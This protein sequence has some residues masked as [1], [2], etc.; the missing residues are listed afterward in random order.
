LGHEPSSR[1]HGR[2]AAPDEEETESVVANMQAMC[3][4]EMNDAAVCALLRCFTPLSVPAGSVLWEQG[5]E[6]D[7]AVVLLSGVLRSE[8]EEVISILFSQFA[9]T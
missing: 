5:G 4:V 2:S 8:L 9:F 1:E 6:P 7:R 3:P